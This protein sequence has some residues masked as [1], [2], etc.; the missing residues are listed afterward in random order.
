VQAI[1]DIGT[2]N[3]AEIFTDLQISDLSDDEVDQLLAAVAAA[4]E[5]VR[6]TFE[7]YVDVYK[8]GLDDYV[9]VGSKIPVGERRVIVAV[10]AL[11]TFVPAPTRMRQR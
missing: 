1:S 3:A 8:A 5:S 4:P 7:Q 6:K 10:G 9:P 2:D 11:M